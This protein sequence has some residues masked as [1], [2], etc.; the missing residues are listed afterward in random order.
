MFAGTSIRRDPHRRRAGSSRR[1]RRRTGWWRRYW[2]WSIRRAGAPA[3]RVRSRPKAHSSPA[4]PGPGAPRSTGPIRRRR[5]RGRRPAHG[6]TSDRN[7]S[8]PA[9]RAS[10]LGVA[11]P[12]EQTVTTVSMSLP[13]SCAFASAFSAASTNSASAPSRKAAVRSGQ[14]CR[15]RYH[16]N[17]LTPWRLMMPVLEKMLESVSN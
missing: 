14:P 1:R 13:E 5:S 12:V 7:P 2:L 8:R 3:S 15:S 4:A 9:T 16:S 6:S 17:G 11:I 10:R